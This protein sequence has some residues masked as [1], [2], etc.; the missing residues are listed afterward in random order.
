M[1]GAVSAADTVSVPPF[2]PEPGDT[3]NQLPPLVVLAVAVQFSVPPPEFERLTVWLG[4]TPPAAAA[5]TNCSELAPRLIT[6]IWPT[7][8]TFRIRLLPLSAMKRF[9]GASTATPQIGRAPCSE[10]E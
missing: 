4:V 6:G 5:A 1:G 2:V 9:P 10:H 7:G 3:L 8:L